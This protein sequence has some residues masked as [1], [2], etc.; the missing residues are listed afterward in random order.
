M[1][2][3]VDSLMGCMP[4]PKWPWAEACHLFADDEAELHEFARKLGL[5]R[6][7]FQAGGVVEHYDLTAWMRGKAVAFGAR[8]VEREFFVEF[9]AA[10]RRAREMQG[11]FL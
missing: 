8:E 9:V 10:R 3:Y 5:K 2:V 11:S 4:S 1:A 7:W 6:E